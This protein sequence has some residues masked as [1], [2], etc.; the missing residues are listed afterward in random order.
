MSSLA[1]EFAKALSTVNRPGAFFVAGTEQILAPG[2]TVEG[3]GPIALPLLPAQAERLIATA[4]RAP[5][6]RGEDTVTDISV[7]RTWQI[8]A[9]RVRIKGKHWLQTIRAIVTRVA[10][11]LGVAEPV[12]TEFYKLLVYDRGSFFV[13]SR[14]RE[15]AGHVRHSGAGAAIGVRGRRR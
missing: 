1:I 12:E 7:R 13:A 6:G 8:D 4:E 10:E 15:S 11:G 5:Y 2:L 14:H 9:S 3:V